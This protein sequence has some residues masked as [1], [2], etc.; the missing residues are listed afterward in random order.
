M[1]W[2]AFLTLSWNAKGCSLRI[3]SI[4]ETWPCL[5]QQKICWP[6]LELQ[7]VIELWIWKEISAIMEISSHQS[8]GPCLDYCI[9]NYAYFYISFLT[10]QFIASK[11]GIPFKWFV[12]LFEFNQMKRC[13]TFK[14]WI[15]TFCTWLEWRESGAESMLDIC[16]IK[17]LL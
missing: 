10:F 7:T 11:K 13:K 17:K 9:I 2:S 12:P 3:N 16:L 5:S 8:I 4:V 6:G 14:P 1:N 15:R